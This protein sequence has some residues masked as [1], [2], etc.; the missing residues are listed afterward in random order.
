M[1]M[2]I[3]T[4]DNDLGLALIGRETELALLRKKMSQIASG[5]G[6]VVL[7]EGEAGVGK[8]RLTSVVEDICAHGQMLFL[9]GR[10]TPENASEPY[11]IL[12]DALQD[13]NG[14]RAR[15]EEG[16]L[17]AVLEESG[18]QIRKVLQ[19][20]EAA[21][22]GPLQ[23]RLFE[24]RFARLIADMS[25]RRP[26]VLCLDDLHRADPLSM[27][28]LGLLTRTCAS[29]AVLILATY[30]P[31]EIRQT[32]EAGRAWSATVWE[33][34]SRVQCERLKLR[35]LTRPETHGLVES[36]LGEAEF[37]QGLVDL[38]HNRTGGVP[39]LLIEYLKT[40]QQEGVWSENDGSWVGL[41]ADRLDVPTAMRAALEP[42]L[43]DLSEREKRLLGHAAVQGE[44]FEGAAVAETMDETPL[45]ILRELNRLQLDRRLIEQSAGGFRFTHPMLA[46]VLRDSLPEY[47]RCTAHGRLATRVAR[48]NPGQVE[49]IARHLTAAGLHSQSLPYL[50]ESAKRAQAKGAYTEAHRF[51][52]QAL[53]I[54]KALDTS[55][56]EQLSLLLDLAA[57]E[58]RLG[59]WS[60]S[61]E[62]SQ[63]SLRLSQRRQNERAGALAKLQ[64]AQLRRH[65]GD[66]AEVLRQSHEALEIF[67][68]LGDKTSCAWVML[69]L[70]EIALERSRVAEAM[71]HLKVAEKLSEGATDRLSAQVELTYGVAAAVRGQYVEA[72]VRFARALRN[73]RKLG[74]DFAICRTF[75]E[76]GLLHTAQGHS[77]NALR[78]H[79]ESLLLARQMG[80]VEMVTRALVGRARA[81]IASDKDQAAA[82][83]CAAARVL[84][85]RM[86]DRRGLASCGIPEAAIHRRR[87]NHAAAEELLWETRTVLQQMEDL[88]GVGECDRELGLVLHARGDVTGARRCLD[89][90]ARFFRQI[91][92]IM[93]ARKTQRMLPDLTAGRS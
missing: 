9:R 3:S 54:H 76:L 23:Q 29:E 44:Q 80:T 84:I 46:E 59:R 47:E 66:W 24:V 34:S 33:L 48:R 4:D 20:R 38:L 7:I 8:S 57:T 21:K 69:R 56:P 87:G 27:K 60:E 36:C 6:A 85:S 12:S 62:H 11:G 81:Y 89:R 52:S 50:T 2:N 88:F 77:Q 91:G 41:S 61:E 68:R 19:S 53:K 32:D 79:D 30:T 75:H 37:D 40:L 82:A 70:G 1:N 90:S 39:L 55:G 17:A 43:D 65:S 92:A 45:G 74:D 51:L 15:R 13:C 10:G 35:R 25:R 86:G 16:E 78:C 63:E 5:T 14:E 28:L 93:S 67:E 31:E 71:G 26:V 64:L 72:V 73:F 18:P 58:D 22:D 49:Q 83:S 42:R